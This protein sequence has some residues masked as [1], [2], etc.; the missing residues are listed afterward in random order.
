MN[1][2]VAHMENG[3]TR[4][5]LSGRLDIEGT[6]KIDSEFNRVAEENKKVVVDLSDVTFI[7]SLGLRTLITGAKATANNGGKMVILNPQPNVEKVLRTSRV[8]TVIPIVGD[9][10]T[11]RRFSVL[12][13]PYRCGA[14]L[15][16]VGSALS[17]ALFRTS[18]LRRVG[19]S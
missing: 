18:R 12:K 16:I 13:C 10:T 15:R 4:V 19:S 1:L 8:D 3:T 14:Y 9:L 7:A 11:S 6:L 5:V 17:M 2:E